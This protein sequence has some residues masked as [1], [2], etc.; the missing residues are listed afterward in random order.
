MTYMEIIQ[1][2][3]PPTPL[4]I[5]VQKSSNPLTLDV[6][7]QTK[8]P[9][10]NGNQSIQIRHNP[11]MT[12]ICYQVLPLA[13]FFSINS[14]IS[15]SFHLTLLHLAEASLSAFSWLT[16]VCEVAQKYYEMYFTYNRTVHV[17][18]RN[19]NK[20]SCLIQIEH[21]FHCLI[22]PRNNAMV[23]LKDGFTV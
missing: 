18:E 9:S 22:Y 19:Q 5:Y 12:L 10:P 13:F 8:S 21:L 23:S 14:L 2:S 16:L 3:R 4:F 6:Q 15:S 17:N 11:R 7:F 1:F 20:K